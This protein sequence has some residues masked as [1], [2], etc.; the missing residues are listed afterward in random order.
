MKR[1]IIAT[2]V[3]MSAIACGGVDGTEID[4]ST[5]P[6]WTPEEPNVVI[7]F[8]DFPGDQVDYGPG[9]GFISDSEKEKFCAEHSESLL[10]IDEQERSNE[11]QRLEQPVKHCWTGPGFAVAQQNLGN[12]NRFQG[13]CYQKNDNG[14]AFDCAFPGWQRATSLRWKS[15]IALINEFCTVGMTGSGVP[16]TSPVGRVEIKQAFDA[17]KTAGANFKNVADSETAQFSVG[18]AP[19]GEQD[20]STGILSAAGPWGNLRVDGPVSQIGFTGPGAQSSLGANYPVANPV[21]A[22]AWDLGIWWMYDRNMNTK[23]NSCGGNSTQKLNKYRTMLYLLGLHE[24]GHM[25]GFAHAQTGIMKPSITCDDLGDGSSATAPRVP[26]PGIYGD[27]YTTYINSRSSSAI[28]A[29]YFADTSFCGT[30]P[31][32]LA[33]NNHAAEFQE[34]INNN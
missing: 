29:N 22:L 2:L 23:A 30:A 19:T 8:D 5:D 27:L 13:P 32:P 1:F 10:C 12:T 18:C 16:G 26:V 9:M 7:T 3:A 20:N 17:W 25:I 15:E 4:P 33:G 34:L 28:P 24:V 31:H 21:Q 11:I 14:V 6:T